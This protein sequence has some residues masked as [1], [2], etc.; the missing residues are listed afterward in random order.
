MAPRHGH[1]VGGYVP[2]LPTS[3]TSPIHSCPRI[4]PSCMVNTPIVEMHIRATNNSSVTLMASRGL[5]EDLEFWRG[6]SGHHLCHTSRLLSLCAPCPAQPDTLRNL[7]MIRCGGFTRFDNLFET[8]RVLFE[9]L[10]SERPEGWQLPHQL[11]LLAVHIRASP[12][13]QCHVTVE[14]P[15]VRYQ[16]YPRPLQA[17]NA[18][19]IVRYFLVRR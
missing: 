19:L 4:S 5:I 1:R 13:P 8:T 17:E 9:L 15:S 10:F 12:V 3:T 2:A 16:H 7:R 6:H 18:C 11:C 14:F